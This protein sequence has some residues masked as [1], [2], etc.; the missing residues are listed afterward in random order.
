[1]ITVNVFELFVRRTPNKG[2]VVQASRTTNRL[3]DVSLARFPDQ[4]TGAFPPG[5]FFNFFKESI[6]SG[7]QKTDWLKVNL[8][9]SSTF[10]PES[11]STAQQTSDVE[12]L[13]FRGCCDSRD[14]PW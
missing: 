12:E 14:T 13:E 7:Q 4:T 8:G 6:H 1:M 5:F 9:Y 3:N 10:L 2:L 11:A